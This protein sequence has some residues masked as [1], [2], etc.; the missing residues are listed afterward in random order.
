MSKLEITGTG[1]PGGTVIRLDGHD[2]TQVMRELTLNVGAGVVPSLDLTIP[3]F[4]GMRL[5]LEEVQVYLPDET[6]ELLVRIGWTPPEEAE[7]ERA[8]IVGMIRHFF[9]AGAGTELWDDVQTLCG[10][11]ERGEHMSTATPAAEPERES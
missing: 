6:R 7:Q 1:L 11:I 10:R 5:G 2:I 9:S 4:E 8:A 3:V